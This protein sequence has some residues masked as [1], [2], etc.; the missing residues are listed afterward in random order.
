MEDNKKY[1]L[2]C[3]VRS[4]KE[5][6]VAKKQKPDMYKKALGILKGEVEAISSIADL[7]KIKAAKAEVADVEEDDGEEDAD[8]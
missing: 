7:R 4:I 8:E 1:E 2:D 5:V 3:L 6:E